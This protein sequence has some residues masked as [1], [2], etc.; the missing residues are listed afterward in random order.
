MREAIASTKMALLRIK[1]QIFIT[2]PLFHPA[3]PSGALLYVVSQGSNVFEACLRH[4]RG[5]LE[6]NNR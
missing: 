2:T 6:A 5:P 1:T 3:G 4:A